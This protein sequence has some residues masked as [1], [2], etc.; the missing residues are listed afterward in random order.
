MTTTDAK[1]LARVSNAILSELES[2]AQKARAKAQAEK[3]LET[4][5]GWSP[6]PTVRAQHGYIIGRADGWSAAVTAA[7]L[8]SAQTVARVVC[9]EH[10]CEAEPIG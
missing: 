4:E 3:A 8:A 1:T 10:D 2:G 5:L 6:D 7:K 9:D